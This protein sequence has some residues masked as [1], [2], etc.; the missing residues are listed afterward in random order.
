MNRKPGAEEDNAA[1]WTR[2]FGHLSDHLSARV[3]LYCQTWQFPDVSVTYL[4]VH[5]VVIPKR[6][7][8]VANATISELSAWIDIDRK[9]TAIISPRNVWY[10]WMI[11]LHLPLSASLSAF[12]SRCF[13]LEQLWSYQRWTFSNHQTL[14]KKN[15]FGAFFF[16]CLRISICCQTPGLSGN[17]WHSAGFRKRADLCYSDSRWCESHWV[18]HQCGSV[19]RWS[20]GV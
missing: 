9:T 17:L 10:G 1:S 11:R 3:P 2:H 7:E 18:I 20:V 6:N 12:L 16:F 4:S 13:C 8:V 15:I 19:P 14:P 5:T